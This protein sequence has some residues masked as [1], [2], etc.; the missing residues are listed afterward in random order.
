MVGDRQT[1]RES[2]R[3]LGRRGRA[4]QCTTHV[5]APVSAMALRALFIL[6]AILHATTAVYNRERDRMKADPRLLDRACE[7][8]SCYPATGNLLIGRESRLFASSTCGLGGRERYCIVSHLEDRKKCFWCDSSNHTV[9]NPN[10]NHRIQN[11]IYKFHPGTRTKSWWQSENGKENVTVQLDMEA[12]FHLTHLIIQ[13]KTFRPAAMLV[14][15]S[16][17]FGKN[18]RVYRYFAHN[19]DEA[20]PGVPQHA[21]RSLSEV[22]C[23]SRYS[24]VAPSSEGEVIFRVLPPNIN[25]SNPYSE[26][27]QN[28]LRMTNLRIKFT[29]LHTLG[30][31]LLDNRAEIQEKYYYGIYEM[32][33][34]GSCSCYGHASRC[35]PMPGVESKNNMVHGRC[36]CTHNTRGLNCEYCEDFY[37]D[38]PWQ[39]AVGKTS[40][41]CKRCTCNNHATSCHF[42]YAV[43]N[44]TGKISGGVCDEC[45]HN[46]M[47]SNC[48]QCKPFFYR[49]PNLDI[50][51]P[52]I[53]KPCDC[54][55]T[56]SI[57]EGLC[58]PLNDYA[59]NQEAGRC[60]CKTNV[61]GPR[62]DACKDGYWNFDTNNPEGCEACTCVALGT[63]KD[64]GC[65]A[66][67][68]ECICKRYVTGRNCDQCLPQF[69][70]LSDI[71]DGCLPCDC[72]IGG[73]LDNFCDV[74]TGQCKCRPNVTGRRCDQS[75]QNF[76]IPA[77]DAMVYE[78][79]LSLCDSSVDDNAIQIQLCQ[80]VIR[81]P[82]RD[83]RKETWTGPGFM[84]VPEGS[85]L[86]FPIDN[87]MSSMRYKVLI[88]YEPQSNLD[89]E[90]ATVFI[91]EMKYNDDIPDDPN[92][93]CANIRPDDN[94]IYTTLPS[95]QRHVLVER[96]ICLEKDKHYELRI[97]LGQQASHTTNS[98]ASILI[99]SV[100]LIPVFDDLP[101]FSNDTVGLLRRQEFE[102]NNCDDSYYYDLYRDNVPEVCK[103]YHASIGFYVQN[104][105]QACHC[106]MTGSTSHQ[107]EEHGGNCPCKPNVVGRRC[108]RCA[109]G[110]FGFS[111]DGC[112]ACD[113]NNIGALDNFCDA[114]SGQCKCKA[115]TYGLQCDKCQP[116]YFNFPHCQQ[117]DCNGHADQCEDKTGACLDCRDYTEGH[118]CERC[119]EGFYG[120]PKLGV[121]ISCRAC[122]CPGV[123]GLGNSF[124]DRCEL[125]PDTKDVICYCAEG[126]AGS[127]C[128]VCADNYY[129]HPEELGGFC[130]PCE[131]NDNI[132]PTK[133]GNCDPHTG[134]CLQ[135]L[136][137]TAGDYC[138]I[139][140]EGYYGDALTQSCEKCSCSQLGTNFTL[141]N[142]DRITGQCPCHKNVMGM[143]CDQCTEN[144]WKIAV[145][146]GCDPC[147]CDPVGSLSPQ[148]N[149]YIGKC[150]CKNGFGGRQCDQ[151]QENFWGN[152]KVECFPCE[153][154][155]YGSLSAQCMR[156][157]GS[158][159]CQPGIGGKN[160][161]MCARGYIGH[162]IQCTECGECFNNWDVIIDGL[163]VQTQYAIGNASKIKVVGATGA[164]TRDFEEMTKK[165]ADIENLLDSAS[166]GET[167]V[168][169]LLSEVNT[170]RDQLVEE[171]QKVKDSN[172]N[173]SDI[174]SKINLGDVALRDLRENIEKLKNKTADL[175]NNATKLQEANLEGALNLTRE[176]KE[177]AL[178][179]ADDAE[180]VQTIVASTDRQIKN[181]D[182]LIEMQYTT[183]NNTQN[184]NE[185][186]LMELEDQLSE[187]ESQFPKL[188]EKMCG[189]ESDNCD[190]CGG[191]GCG[192][193][194]GISCDRG[195]VT[196]AEKALE[197]ANKTEHRIKEHELSAEDLFRSISQAKQETVGALNKA[198]DIFEKADKLKLRT[199]KITNDSLSVTNELNDFLSN[200]TSTPT[201]VRTLANEILKLSISLEP[202]EITEL[203]H[204][205]NATVSQLTNIENIISETKP[206]LDK[207]KAL[208]LNA[209]LAN[210][211][212]N[213]TL[214]MAN[215][216]L[217]ALDEA[218]IAQDAA[219]I[220]IATARADI[221]AAKED[222]IPIAAE[223]NEAQKKAN[224]TK[225]EVEALQLRLNK[226]QKNI[227]KIESDA[228]QVKQ[229]ADDVVN[230][231]E[232]AEQQART[233]R[234][235]YKNANMSL[236]ERAEK[237]LNSRERAQAL[238]QRATTLAS[239][240]QNQLKSLQNMEDLYNSHASEL[241]DLE[242]KISELN[243]QMSVYLNEI[244]RKS[245]N[246]RSCTT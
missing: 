176:A 207:A 153:C 31:D 65:D 85:T 195:A 83:G 67:T 192:K 120:D 206:D 226:L 140:K 27:V 128:D 233:L 125:D 242:R 79:E 70:G 55:P 218:K 136:H 172:D 145:G 11:I 159:I 23:E 9:N 163:K 236:T 215:K 243:A 36:E 35:L 114:T 117:C 19:C 41:A 46:T 104:G 17:D 121:D 139:C 234:K 30:D 142:C 177:R 245:D 22:V 56:G 4:V 112:K 116:G 182:R 82:F 25:I 239:D 214:E 28:L 61:G 203:S 232:G 155:L 54:E 132:D 48:E 127:R 18:W 143:N 204:R 211:S 44:L 148:C 8:S 220:A 201:D 51:S 119:I 77:L 10:L 2:A 14:E 221:D 208:K 43:Y 149:P 96:P 161:D 103:R 199:D 151:C 107:C 189:Q 78:G 188:N 168:K 196:K 98:R 164:Y 39:P 123:K 100:V 57:D 40:N 62:C 246:Y 158:C 105:G 130:S 205:I 228:E 229:E 53:C 94:E 15:R 115:N 24:G 71:D 60:H 13:F 87:V 118:R 134:K 74:I 66:G 200:T 174:T 180:F 6:C 45:Q 237:T 34:R 198:K 157:N 101:F 235:T 49:D 225:D 152:P 179:A 92:S 7:L 156:E 171:E 38:L 1:A 129:G 194:G 210:N 108:D 202:K 193:C 141:G 231:A 190:V 244:T 32:T 146:T 99:D 95:N 175:K 93:V 124:A 68:G 169:D 170:L 47:G 37:N 181:T 186:K 137:N 29:R 154:D 126:Y 97:F 89:W 144:H 150:D 102:M 76:Y 88:R 109:P 12:E 183:F 111:S 33:V 86:V 21:Q 167:T 230:R 173:L 5:D 162:G 50:Q 219:E 106:D 224:D 217:E 91:K 191:A 209:T 75:L 241:S 20:F 16:F 42:D 63:V 222:L 84:K 138:E 238:L 184:E 73:S 131:C 185:K 72:D 165:L 133:P 147:D 197:F 216:V 26:E 160:C 223:T 187:L 52:D 3:V 58:D 80:V 69:Y 166:V 59:T 135:C 90:Q 212:A 240:T 113:C 110:T 178:K 122:P 64:R 213:L 227:L 81:E